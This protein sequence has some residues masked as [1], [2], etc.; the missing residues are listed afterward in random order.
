[1]LKKIVFFYYILLSQNIPNCAKFLGSH[2]KVYK[3]IIIDI[4]ID[5]IIINIMTSFL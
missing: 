3:Y 4:I 5:I 1:M 2:C